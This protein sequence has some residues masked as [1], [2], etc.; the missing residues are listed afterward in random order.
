M[1]GTSYKFIDMMI[2][3][4]MRKILKLKREINKENIKLGL[5]KAKTDLYPSNFIYEAKGLLQQ[6]LLSFA[7]NNLKRLIKLG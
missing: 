1:R 3:S 4:K 6:Y 2:H 7:L 5:H